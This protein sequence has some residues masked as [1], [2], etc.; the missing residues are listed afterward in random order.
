MI[1]PLTQMLETR[2]QKVSEGVAAAERAQEELA[3]IEK[4]RGDLLARAGQEADDVLAAARGAAT[5]K[6]RELIAQSEAS[7]QALLRE[8]EAQAQELER[9]AIENS[10]KEVAKLIVL[11]M[12]RVDKE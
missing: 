12:E 8:A 3:H 7:A 2:R 5:E 10:K 9:A 4:T 11:G 6:G 1:E